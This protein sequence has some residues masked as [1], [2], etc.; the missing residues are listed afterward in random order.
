MINN[1]EKNIYLENEFNN[2]EEIYYNLKKNNLFTDSD[3]DEF[4]K[5]NEDIKNLLNKN[6]NNI[7]SKTIKSKTKDIEKPKTDAFRL[8]YNNHDNTIPISKKSQKSEI[9][10]IDKI[11]RFLKKDN[12]NY[13]SNNNFY[14]NEKIIN[15]I[16]NID[17]LK[18]QKEI[19]IQKLKKIRMKNKELMSYV[20]PYKQSMTNEDIENEQRLKYIKYLDD[21][22]K[23]CVLINNKLKQKL[24][25]NQN[26]NIKKKIEYLINKQIKEYEKLY[27]DDLNMNEN[28]NDIKYKNNYTNNNIDVKCELSLSGANSEYK[29]NNVTTD[30]FINSKH[31]NKMSGNLKGNNKNSNVNKLNK[32][33]SLVFCGEEKNKNNSLKPKRNNS[34]TNFLSSIK[35]IKNSKITRNNNT[36]SSIT[37]SHDNNNNNKN[38]VNKKNDLRSLKQNSKISNGI[39]FKV[40]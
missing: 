15:T 13:I 8:N 2:N 21:K 23:E 18:N 1:V 27:T 33:N 3:N 37:S 10:N 32:N 7:N 14:N 35:Y 19:L 39:N 36:S 26:I 28:F 29:I 22:I 38:N 25:T 24:M 4:F 31:K 9:Q 40:K 11:L 6:E 17:D 20:E 5:K 34:K 30:G 16:E 12:D